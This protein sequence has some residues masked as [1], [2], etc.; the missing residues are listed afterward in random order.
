MSVKVIK[1]MTLGI[2]YKPYRWRQQDHLCISGLGFFRL[3]K[4]NKRF[5]TENLQWPVVMKA[6]P[7]GQMLDAVMPKA[8]PEALVAGNACAPQGTKL[9]KIDVSI[10][11]AN[12]VKKLRVY[13]D[14]EWLYGLVPLYK[15]TDPQPFSKIPLIYERAYGG[16]KFQLNPLGLGYTG[17]RLAAFKG[18]NQGVMPNIEYP[19]EPVKNNHSKYMPA[20]FGALDIRWPQRQ[21][22][23]GTYDQKWMDNDYPGLPSDIDFSTY[24]TA[25]Q[26]QWLENEIKGGE[27]YCLRGMHPEKP[28]IEGNLPD[29]NVKAFVLRHKQ[30]YKQAEYVDLKPE[31]I[32]F[33]PE[34]ELGVLIYRGQCKIDDSDALDIA[35]ITLAYES[36]DESGKPLSHYYDVI[37]KRTDIKTAV[38]HAFN[39]SQLA[40]AKNKEEIA[41]YKEQI[42]KIK[43]ENQAQQQAN[44]EELLEDAWSKNGGKPEGAEVPVIPEPIFDAISEEELKSGDFDLSLL[45]EQSDALIK[46]TKED[47]KKKKE[48]LEIKKRKMIEKLPMAPVQDKLQKKS[49][50]LEEV[51]VKAKKVAIDLIGGEVEL[52]DD[53]AQLLKCL[54]QAE[55]AG[56]DVS[57][58]RED[59]LKNFITLPALNRQARRAAITVDKNKESIYPEVAKQLGQQIQQWLTQGE[60]LIGRDFAGAD[61]SGVNLSG[62]DFSEV[63]LDGANLE[64]AC[65]RGAMLK[66]AVFLGA[67]LCGADLSEADIS[68][69]NLCEANLA[70]ALLKN[71]NLVKATMLSA[72]MDHAD[73]TGANLSQCIAIKSNINNCCFDKTIVNQSYFIN[74]QGKGS[75]WRNA[76]LGMALFSN[77]ELTNADFTG[78]SL[79][80]C[81]FTGTNL[82]ESLFF[83]S[84][85]ERIVVD[86]E[87]CLD[88]AN[89][90]SAKAVNCGFRGV[91]MQ[92]ANLRQ[93]RFD[94]CDFGLVNLSDSNLSAAVLYRSI[95]MQAKLNR[96]DLTS[97][98]FFQALC[99]K[100]DMSDADL[101]GA[102]LIQAEMTEAILENTKL[103]PEQ[104]KKRRAA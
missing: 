71:A 38:Y 33:F 25:P 8:H 29:Y 16:E 32:W 42:Q 18:Q 41:A 19:N 20:G 67:N 76:K 48:E 9:A 43:Q 98:D 83:K 4:N 78:A 93:S 57:A 58:E 53:V 66:G 60:T 3:G 88:K 102:N 97:T 73:F 70:S 90:E 1:P 101:R 74:A 87:A 35:S 17:K 96:A 103:D 68:E 2:L 6:L 36:Q 95:F 15:I 44:M 75:S 12:Y 5:L 84:N 100:V 39:E 21:Q 28:C 31:T 99:R 55:E 13:G 24:N 69:A 92:Y 7:K 79:E 56:K 72:K 27:T 46:K 64:G 54:M 61:L 45:I 37:E 89:F 26:D 65:L 82:K 30:E 86:K 52:D 80:R 51:I 63:M 14:R 91:S 62:V 77:A 81:I 94:Q 10:E 85:L 50:Q 49:K 11:L 59:I 47:A 34:Q 40:P 22:H 23:T 104:N